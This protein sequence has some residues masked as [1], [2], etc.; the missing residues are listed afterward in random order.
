MPY[1]PQ[2]DRKNAA[3]V[4]RYPADTSGELNFQFTQL[5]VAYMRRHGKCYAT[6]NDIVGALEGAKSEFQR[7]VVGPYE[8]TKIKENGD[9]Y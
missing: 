9:V 8:D 5:I 6:M 7:R 2:D 3:P 1:I 4:L